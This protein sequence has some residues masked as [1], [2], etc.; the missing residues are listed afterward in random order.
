MCGV[1]A[2]CL[3]GSYTKCVQTRVGVTGVKV[4]HVKST[5]AV[6]QCVSAYAACTA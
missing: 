5:S 4:D 1:H 3:A 6:L 2:V